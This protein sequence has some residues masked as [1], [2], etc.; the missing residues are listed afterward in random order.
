MSLR[1]VARKEFHECRRSYTLLGLAGLYVLIAVF[2]AVIQ[3]VPYPDM[4]REASTSTLAL[5]NS[6]TQPGAA[7]VPLLGLLV[8]YHTIGGAR[9][10]G[11]IRLTLSLPN[12][13]RA[14][15]FGTFLGRFAVVATVIALA[16]AGIG[17]VA[18][19]T[20]AYFDVEALVVNTAVSVLY[21][22]VYVAIGIGFS[23]FTKSRFR[24]LLGAAGLFWLF[25]IVWDAFM[26]LVQVLFIG[27]TLPE[28]SQLPGW[29]E[30]VWLLNPSSAIVY[31]RRTLLPEY[32]ELVFTPRTSAA[33]L[34]DWVGVVVLFVWVVVPLVV[35]Y[36]RFER[37]DLE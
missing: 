23:A 10:S 22:G 3:W 26:F 6:L 18:L 37:I 11:S 25:F 21:G 29:M 20:Y 2:F 19:A 33:Y 12:T 4:S 36:V 13:R 1:A 7:F 9:E 24:A 35:G 30:Y 14:V 31:T 28:G 17:I 34:Q 27:P 15:V 32:H 16:S 5:L 8:G